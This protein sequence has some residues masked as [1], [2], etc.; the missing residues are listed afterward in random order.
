MSTIT[1]EYDVNNPKALSLIEYVR[2]MPFVRERQE[3]KERRFE[4]IHGLAY[5]HEERIASAMRGY[6]DAKAGRVISHEEMGKLI[7]SW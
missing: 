3:K 2:S 6:E 5:T 7:A 1:L 4:R